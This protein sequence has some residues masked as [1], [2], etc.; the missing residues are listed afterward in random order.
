MTIAKYYCRIFLLSSVEIPR[1]INWGVAPRRKLNPLT[2]PTY[3]VHLYDV[4]VDDG[5][6]LFA[7]RC[8][9]VQTV[10]VKTV[11]ELWLL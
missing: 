3:T 11:T 1:R 4:I 9:E 2:F 6:S 7:A 5:K 8:E 10:G